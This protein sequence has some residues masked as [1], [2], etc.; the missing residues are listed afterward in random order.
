[1]RHSHSISGLLDACL[2]RIFSIKMPEYFREI[3]HGRLLRGYDLKL[4]STFTMFE[5]II[6]I[7]RTLVAAVPSLLL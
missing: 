4:T 6:E 3:N 7:A 2:T 1:M 5:I